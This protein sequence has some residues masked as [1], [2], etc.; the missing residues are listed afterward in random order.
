[1]NS[2]IRLN[3]SIYDICLGEI[4]RSSKVKRK[5][6]FKQAALCSHFPTRVPGEKYQYCKKKKEKKLP[7]VL[8]STKRKRNWN[9]REKKPRQRLEDISRTTTTLQV[10]VSVFP[11]FFLC[12][13]VIYRN[14]FWFT[15]TFQINVQANLKDP[16]LFSF[17][18]FLLP[19][20]QPSPSK[21]LGANSTET[22]L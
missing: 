19:K 21:F 14:P 12:C 7:P 5:R 3:P 10:W 15:N 4:I 9:F 8:Q 22:Q 17:F 2:C 11:S 18:Y 1:M 16:F 13:T 20:Q 6:Y